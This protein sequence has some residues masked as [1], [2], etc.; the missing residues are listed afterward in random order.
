MDAHIGNGKTLIEVFAPESNPLALATPQPS[1]QNPA[2]VYLAGLPSENSRRVQSQALAK[3]AEL[4]GA[5]DLRAVNWAA[6]RFQHSALIRSRLMATYP[7]ATTNRLLSALRGT[8]K[9]AW[10]LGQL[11]TDDYMRAVDLE[12]EKSETLPAGR[13]LGSGEIAALIGAC[14]NDPTP[15]GPRDATI[16]ALMAGC[17]LRRDEVVKLDLDDYD[18]ESGSLKVRGKGRKERLVWLVN[19]SGRAMHDWLE[20]RGRESGPLFWPVNKSGKIIK[21]YDPETDDPQRMSNQ[22]VYNLLSKRAEE[23]GVRLT[24]HDL[25]RTFITAALDAGA[26]PLTVAKIVG[27]A[28]VNTTLRYDRRGEG[29]KQEAIGR[30]HIP[31]RGRMV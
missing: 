13:A 25:R 16:I 8:L 20:L 26:D 28:S 4:L 1:D 11:P 19:G 31:Y 12:G 17:G 29:A 23:A 10:R 27:H 18:P 21:Q 3:I 2:L 14:E 24:P 7:A 15:A 6:L 22:A 5:D 30:V 9:A